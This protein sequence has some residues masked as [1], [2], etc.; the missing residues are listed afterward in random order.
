LNFKSIEICNFGRYKG[1]H[2]F[3]TKSTPEKNVIL[4]KAQNDRGK[5]TLFHAIKYALYGDKPDTVRG[6]INFQSAAE[7]N[8]EM[9]VDIKFEHEGKDYRVQRKQ[10]FEQT[11]RGEPIYMSGDEELNIFDENGPMKS[12]G[13]AHIN[14]QDWID[15]ILPKDASQFFLFDGEEI[16]KYIEK[17]AEN[18]RVAI[19]KVLGIKE[20]LNAR[21]DLRDVYVTDFEKEYSQKLRAVTK[22]KE[23]QKDLEELQQT[24]DDCN[25]V[26]EGHTASLNAAGELKQKYKKELQTYQS[27]REIVSK[28]D[29]AQNTL[30]KTRSALKDQERELAK[31]RNDAGL[32]LLYPLLNIIDKTEENPPTKDQWESYTIQQMLKMKLEKCLCG[33]PIDKEIKEIL[34]SKILLMKPSKVS[35]LKRFVERTLIDIKPDLRTSSMNNAIAET[36][37]LK[38]QYDNL[39]SEIKGYDDQIKEN[40]DIGA[41]IKE[42][43]RKYEEAVKDIDRIES[44]IERMKSEKQKAEA[45]QLSLQKK[46]ETSINDKELTLATLR[47]N[48]C[49]KVRKAVEKSISMFYEKRKPVLE[50]HVS[51]IFRQLT[52]NPNLYAGLKIGAD[53][54]MKVIR[55]DGTELPTYTYSPS[56]GAAQIVATAMIGGLN[57]FTTRKAPVVI[58]TPLGRLDPVHKENLISY[59]S[60]IGEQVII[61]YQPSELDEDWIRIF[62][63]SIASEWEIESLPASPD[64]SKIQRIRNF[65]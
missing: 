16:Q 25:T 1:P 48:F 59:Y 41:V 37:N 21:D 30:N 10:K 52:N 60:Q 15:H 19:E 8:G 50:K 54:E 53:F 23:Q 11:N 14:K 57:K 22:D 33:R 51:M 61:F 2:L 64:L 17:P 35:E 63:D 44:D 39:V 5:T 13:P 12:I 45:R 38:H 56:A 31:R 3:D 24:I 7:G 26:I 46:I 40:K 43:E 42:Y 62:G 28:R 18:I 4:V 32:V 20:L 29:V 9:Y 36:G 27:I 34:H 58:D 47:K 49:E 65:I 6:W 55:F